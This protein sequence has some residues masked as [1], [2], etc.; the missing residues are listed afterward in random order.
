[1]IHG[2]FRGRE[3]LLTIMTNAGGALAFPPLGTTQ[4]ARF[5]LLAL[6]VQRIHIGKKRF[7]VVDELS[8]GRHRA[9]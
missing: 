1:M 6:D 8:H 2:Q 9:C 4:V 3:L 5:I 7:H